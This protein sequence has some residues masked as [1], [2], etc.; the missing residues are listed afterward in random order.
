MMVDSSPSLRMVLT[1]LVR[2]R[3]SK[4]FRP[5][6]LLDRLTWGLERVTERSSA[7]TK[8]S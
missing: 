5:R 3:P 6:G 8:E 1:I 2:E 7:A 4:T